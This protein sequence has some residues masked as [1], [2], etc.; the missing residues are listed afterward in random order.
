MYEGLQEKEARDTK[1]NMGRFAGGFS[2]SQLRDRS[3]NE[4]E[5]CRKYKSVFL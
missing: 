5:C 1:Q 4:G 3:G 2:V